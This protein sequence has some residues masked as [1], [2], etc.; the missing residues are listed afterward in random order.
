MRIGTD[1][2]PGMTAFSVRPSRTPPAWPSI[3][4]RS[5]MLIDASYTPGRL[6]WPLTQYSFG[7]PFFSGPSDAYHSGPLVTINGTL[8]N[9]STLLTAVGFPYR[10]TSAGNGGLFRGCARFPSSDSSSAVSSPASYAPA[11]RCTYT[12]QSKPEPRMFLPSRPASYA[13]AMARS[14]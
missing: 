11:P 13:S 9:V 7:P 14:R 4:S 5:V 1:D 10:P 3:N 12:S 2:P 6:T 8:H